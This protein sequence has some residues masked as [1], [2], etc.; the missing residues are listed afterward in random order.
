MEI[1]LPSVTLIAILPEIIL[2]ALAC[3]FFVAEPFIPKE[4]KEWMGYFSIGALIFSGLSLCALWGMNITTF[5][6]MI[7]LDNYSIFFKGLFLVVAML[8]ILIS[9]KYIKI[10]EINFGEYY[11]LILFATVGMMLMS[12][13]TDLLTIYISLELMSFSF[14]ILTAFMKKD[15]RSREAGIKYFLTG[16]FTSGLI[17]YGIAFLYGLTGST[18]LG[19]ISAYVSQHSL[20]SSPMLFV[21]IVLLVAGFGFKIAV[22]PFHMWAPD[23]YEGAP[24][25]V[26]AFLSAGSK[27]AAFSAM[28]RIFVTGLGSSYDSWWQLLWLLSILTMT[29]GN[30]TALVQTNFKRL[31]AYSSIAHAGYILF[32][33]VAAS[34]TGMAAVLIYSVA[35]AIMTLGAFTMIILLCR[36]NSRGDQISDFKGLARTHPAVA[37]AFVIFA[38]S[39]VGIPPTAG[40]IGKLFLF[41]AAIQGSFYW[42][43]II[44]ILNSTVS[45]Y[46][47]FKVVMVMYMQEPHDAVPLSFS[48]ALTVALFFMS[49]ATLFL[50]LYP[51]PLIRAAIQ[52]V[53]IFL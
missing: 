34:R 32:G 42:L 47:Y 44:G 8:A 2:T 30:I 7:T 22:V 17:L 37:G 48:P 9:V 12:S 27:I 11:G 20:S 14:Y 5:S 16:A 21:A 6:G 1:I 28:L 36:Q 50:G 25:T 3:I 38:L 26:T 31:M 53:Q 18:D 45:L 19:S 46:Y 10:E 33:F 23:V 49:F 24:T 39:L 15:M 41:N 13:A 29:L 4:K 52:S 51:E 43:A 40:F 35:Y